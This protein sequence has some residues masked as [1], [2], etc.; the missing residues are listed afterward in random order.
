MSDLTSSARGRTHCGV[1]AVYTTES[2][3]NPQRGR[4]LN[5]PP[6]A[7]S[8]VSPASVQ[9]VGFLPCHNSCVMDWDSPTTKMHIAEAK[10][11]GCVLL[12]PGQK[13]GY[14]TY[15]LPCGHEQDVAIVNMRNGQMS[16]RTCTDIR[17]RSEA[18]SAGC[19]LLGPGRNARY[20]LYRLPCGHEHEARPSR[21]RE[22]IFRCRACIDS[23]LSNEAAGFGC[24]LLGLGER[25]G[26]RIY[27]LPCGHKQEI[28]TSAMRV[29]RFRCQACQDSKL[30]EEA[31]AQGC[32][33]LGPGR[34][35]HYRIYR[36]PCGHQTEIT[37]SGVRKGSFRC[38]VCTEEKLIAEAQAQGCVLLGKVKDANY[39]NYRL[40]CGHE[41]A[42]VTSQMRTGGFRC[43]TCIEEKFKQDAEAQNCTLNGPGR[44]NRYRVYTLPCGH[45]QEVS[46]HQMRTGGFR[47]Q[48]CFELKLQA[49]AK[50]QNSTLLGPGTTAY[51]RTYRLGCG[52]R[53]EVGTSEMRDGQFRCQTC[54]EYSYTLPSNAYLLHIQVGADEWLKLGYAKDVEFRSSQYGLPENA[55][56]S[57]L[58]IR[59]FATGLEAVRFEKSLHKRYRNQRLSSVEVADFHASSGRNE[60][61]PVLLAEKLTAAFSNLRE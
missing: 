49:E 29:G 36:P 10:A 44:N 4:T 48:S 24:E 32:E 40:P 38:S 2:G 58:A 25:N 56:V 20:R 43:R 19:V 6:L 46:T 61:Y 34:S 53:Q 42:V 22:G 3:C 39:R 15:Q 28:G 52:H 35:C 12:G 57:I 50:L 18:D 45:D 23:A 27:R 51:Y 41:Q 16:C 47:C 13:A 55:V 9:K 37:T 21:I 5:R 1:S 8:A 60:C 14:R 30:V 54:E 17:L 7:W 59:E 31:K 11:Q 33:I 26:T